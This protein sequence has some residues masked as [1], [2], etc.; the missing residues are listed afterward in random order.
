ML[1]RPD[2]PG[3]VSDPRLRMDGEAA[4]DDVILSW[5]PPL[6]QPGVFIQYYAVEWVKWDGSAG[7]QNLTENEFAL[8]VLVRFFDLSLHAAD[9]D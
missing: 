5:G 4:D 8:K 9:N 3:K 6:K 7:A 1:T 2:V